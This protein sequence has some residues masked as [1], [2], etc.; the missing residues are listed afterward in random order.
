[1]LSLLH[2]NFDISTKLFSDLA[3][4]LDDTSAKLFFP[5]VFIKNAING[6]IFSSIVTVYNENYFLVFH[7][8]SSVFFVAFYRSN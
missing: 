2:N 4:F 5:C 8:V 6:E 3:K 1:M 7:T